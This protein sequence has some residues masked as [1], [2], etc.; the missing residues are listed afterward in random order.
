MKTR[1]AKEFRWEMSHRLP[2]HDGLCK[3]VHGHS[4]KLLVEIEGDLNDNGM[5][6]DYYDLK[7]I[8]F[9]LIDKLDHCCLCDKNDSV[10]IDFLNQNEMKYLVIDKY[11]TAENIAQFI[12]EELSLSISKHANIDKIK[13]RLFETSEV[14]AEVELIMK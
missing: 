2:F 13:L 8:V 6:L 12:I 3:N 4:Y 10:L 14:Y 5:L 1:I 7:K 9:P 11:T